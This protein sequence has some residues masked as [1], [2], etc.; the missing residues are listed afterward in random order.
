MTERVTQ[1]IDGTTR[2]CTKQSSLAVIAV[3]YKLRLIVFDPQA[4]YIFQHP[5]I[6]L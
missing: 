3:W 2:T 4:A 6:Q 5:N 1:H